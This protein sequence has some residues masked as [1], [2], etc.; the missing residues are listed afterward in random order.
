M[1]PLSMICEQVARQKIHTTRGEDSQSEASDVQDELKIYFSLPDAS[2]DTDPLKWWPR[3]EKMLP[4]PSRMARQFIV[5]SLASLLLLLPSSD[6]S[7]V[8]AKTSPS[9]AKP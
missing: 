2:L 3:H 4:C 5:S 9:N 8:W 6:C 1:R 7:V